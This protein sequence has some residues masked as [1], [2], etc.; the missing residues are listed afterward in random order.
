MKLARVTFNFS[1]LDHPPSTK[2][3]ATRLAAN[4]GLAGRGRGVGRSTSMSTSELENCECLSPWEDRERDEWMAL[5]LRQ[6]LSFNLTNADKLGRPANKPSKLPSALALR[7]CLCLQLQT[8]PA[9][10]RPIWDSRYLPS[11]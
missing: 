4:G 3:V 6:H 5:Q 11:K 10:C 9:T 7:L 1:L 2:Q 8:S